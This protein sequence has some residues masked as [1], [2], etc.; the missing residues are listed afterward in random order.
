MRH[1]AHRRD[2]LT[3]A[4]GATAGFGMFGLLGA[5][6]SHAEIAPRTALKTPVLGLIG[7]GGMGRANTETFIH[8]KV[9][10][11]CICDV[12]SKHAGEAADAFEKKG[13]KRPEIVK[14]FRTLLDRKD[15]DA[16]VI[17]TP[18]HWHAL[19]TVL[20]AEA[21][22]DMYLEKPISHDIHE[23]RTMAAAAA[24]HN[25][26]VQVGT[27]QRSTREFVAALDY[28]RSGKLGRV[29]V[30]RAWKT[31]D[32]HLGNNSPVPPPSELDYDFWIGPAEF[33]PYTERNCHYNWRWYWNTAAGMTGDWGVHMID[34]ALLGLGKGGDDVALPEEVVC[35]GGKLAFPDDDRNT[36]DTQL[37]LLKFP[38]AILQWETNRRPLDGEHDNGTQFIADNGNTLTVWRGGWSLKTADNKDIEKPADPEGMD[39]LVTH[40]AEFLECVESRKAP[41]SNIASM[42]KTTI[43][44]HLINASY[45]AKSPVR[46][47][48]EKLDIVG[49][50]G[51][52]TQSYQRGYRSPWVLPSY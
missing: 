52:A 27:W 33:V 3:A 1:R 43:L 39:G 19:P 48:P 28:V 31:D 36:P 8:H 46:F 32:A 49:D 15:I 29:V 21:G 10:V 14:D 17:A 13:G 34:I 23:A 38:G 51:K 4:G 42:A 24:K 47:D 45:L 16:V 9:P 22:K 26:V 44:C 20:A 40:V 25:R 5:R 18:D 35:H 12:D 2:F 6:S 30:A 7:C 37:A 41:R 11:A 50:A